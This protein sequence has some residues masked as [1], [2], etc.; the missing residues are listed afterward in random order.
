MGRNDTLVQ[1]VMDLAK[2]VEE[3]EVQV[4]ELTSKKNSSNSS[5]PPSQ[6]QGRAIKNKSLRK[7]VDVAEEGNLATKDIAW[8]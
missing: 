7:K 6:D 8:K 3:L 2:R 5:L 1:K 4:C